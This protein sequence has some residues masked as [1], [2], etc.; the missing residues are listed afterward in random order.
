MCSYT[1]C[2]SSGLGR[3]LF[4]KRLFSAIDG[5]VAQ[6][7]C[8]VPLGPGIDVWRSCRIIVGLMRAPCALTGGWERFQPYNI[9]ASHCRLRHIG[10]E[11]CGHGLTKRRRETSSV[12]F[13]NELLVLLGFPPRSGAALLEGTLPLRY[14]AVKF[15]CRVPTWRLPTCGHVAGLVTEN[16]E[17]VGAVHVAP[18][19]HASSSVGVLDR[20]AGAGGFELSG[21]RFKKVRLSRRTPASLVCQGALGGSASSP[22][23]EE[24]EGWCFFTWSR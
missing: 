14:C 1:F 9:G 24:A 6:F 2:M 15:A 12:H 20:G 21:R 10:W 4:L 19:G 13:L 3:G 5:L 23:L 11:K 17:E 18:C 16:D 22:C 8:R 7:K